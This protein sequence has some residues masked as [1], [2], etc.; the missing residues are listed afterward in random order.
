MQMY[1]KFKGFPLQKNTHKVWGL[2]YKILYND[3]AKKWSLNSL[4]FPVSRGS[5]RSGP[6]GRPT[7]QVGTSL[8]A[9]PC[10]C[11][12]KAAALSG[13]TITTGT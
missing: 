5:K 12:T 7:S 6:P 9:A 13:E 8:G 10:R 4:F 11:E 2:G 3:P 1:G